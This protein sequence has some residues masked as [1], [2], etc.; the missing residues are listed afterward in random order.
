M[1][2]QYVFNVLKKARFWRRM[3]AHNVLYREHQMKQN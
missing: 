3:Q 2:I 1:E